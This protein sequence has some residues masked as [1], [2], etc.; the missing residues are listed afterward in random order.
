MSIAFAVIA[1]LLVGFVLAP[2]F[3]AKLFKLGK[4]RGEFPKPSGHAL[5]DARKKLPG[6]EAKAFKLVKARCDCAH[7]TICPQGRNVQAGDPYRCT[8]WKAE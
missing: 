1:L 6:V 8:I 2:V 4:D 5:R 7:D 3:L